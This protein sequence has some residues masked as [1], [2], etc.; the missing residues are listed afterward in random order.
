[1]ADSEEEIMNESTTTTPEGTPQPQGQQRTGRLS[2]RRLRA[3]TKD[4]P[5]AMLAG[6]ATVAMLAGVEVGLGALLGLG[7]AA[8]VATDA[9]RD[10]RQAMLN[11]GRNLL[12]PR[13][14]G[15][16]PTEQAAAPR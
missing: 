5:L 8:M 2:I 1:L 14:G 10:L 11:R 15:A 13:S 7:A 12:H 9:G 3:L 6:A 4:H 16:P